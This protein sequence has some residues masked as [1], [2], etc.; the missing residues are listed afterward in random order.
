MRIF[1]LGEN[2]LTVEFGN[3]I[4]LELNRQAL[5]LAEY[6]QKNPFPGFIETVPAYAS[7]TLF[8]HPLTV[9]KAFVEY[10]SAFDAVTS[11]VETAALTSEKSQG[12]SK[13]VIKIP[14]I[15]DRDSSPDLEVIS[16]FS[17]L[18]MDEVISIYLERTYTVFMLGFLPGFPYMGE[19]DEKIA[20]PRKQTPRLKV[21]KGSVGIAG[22]Q[23]G[24]YPLESP[25]GWQIIG[26]TEM[27]IFD[28]ASER[29][30]GLTPGDEVRFVRV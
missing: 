15:I 14:I 1:P 18:P 28:P 12:R 13:T 21:P 8:Y 10:P 29:P 19:V 5:Q 7:T 24:I 23:T 22:K 17:G 25:G 20:C 11:L 3:E 27:Q 26:R 6:F 30:C 4:S 9:R 16:E 2:A